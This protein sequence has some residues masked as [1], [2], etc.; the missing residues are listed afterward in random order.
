MS[1]KD[2]IKPVLGFQPMKTAPDHQRLC[3]HERL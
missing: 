2:L 1:C 3:D